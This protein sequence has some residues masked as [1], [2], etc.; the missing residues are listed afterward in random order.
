MSE[1][2]QMLT[3]EDLEKV[4]GGHKKVESLADCPDDTEEIKNKMLPKHKHTQHECPNPECRSKTTLVKKHYLIVDFG[5]VL[6]EGQ[7][8]TKCGEQWIIHE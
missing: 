7:E 6:V 1:E 8:C 4:S 5:H 3:I 2:K